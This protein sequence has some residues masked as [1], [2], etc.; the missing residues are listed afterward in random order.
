MPGQGADEDV[1]TWFS[2][3]EWNVLKEWQKELYRNVMKEVH[4]ALLSLGPLIVTT[5]FSLKTKEQQDLIH[6]NSQDVTR[7]YGDRIGDREVLY[8][9]NVEDDLNSTNPQKN[10]GRERNDCL[11]PDEDPNSIVID[12]LS[13]EVGG[14]RM[15]PA[16]EYEMISFCIKEDDAHSS[17]DNPYS[18]RPQILSSDH[19]DRERQQSHSRATD[20]CISKDEANYCNYDQ[21]SE[22]KPIPSM[23]TGHAGIVTIDT[24]C[25]KDEA[26]AYSMECHQSENGDCPGSPVGIG[27][28]G[29]RESL[30]MSPARCSYRS[31][32][33]IDESQLLVHM[34]MHTKRKAFT[35]S[36]CGMCFTDR[37][38]L[39][40]HKSLHMGKEHYDC[41]ECA[42]TFT[43]SS[44]LYQHQKIHTGEKPLKGT[45]LKYLNPPSIL[46][47]CQRS[48]M[49]VKHRC[50]ECDKSFS[51]RST[52]IIHQR[53]HTGEKPYACTECKRRFRAAS[54]LTDHQ[55]IHTGEKPYGCTE[56]RRRFNTFSNLKSH[57]RIHSGEKPYECT[58]CKKS[59]CDTS[60]L[61]NHQRIHTGEKPYE[62]KECKKSFTQASDLS[63]HRRVHTGEK[64][65]ECKKCKKRFSQISNLYTHQR[66]HFGNQP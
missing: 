7:N 62:C 53:L 52:L 26:Y 17:S 46:R 23:S 36:V 20:V 29:K 9:I 51:Q 6:T 65:Y 48:D 2:E 60:T 4:Q 34:R 33:F 63:K 8:S 24:S 43:T 39:I 54:K 38:N 12:D 14:R 3:E 59:F 47:Q 58:E 18:E 37:P 28:T 25:I 45:E 57:Q 10:E 40:R 1:R 15:D 16:S 5:V 41:T 56:C 30:Q 35:C 55:K 42:E 49:G 32:S 22:R 11:S 50:T 13:E 21:E 27:V 31:E 61:R 66:V 44:N 64:P 19:R